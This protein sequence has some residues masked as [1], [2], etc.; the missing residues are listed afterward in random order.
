MSRFIKERYKN[1]KSYAPG[2]QPK[3]SEYVKLNTNE[4]P[5]PPAP[6]VVKALKDVDMERLRL[7]PD[8]TG[9]NLKCKLAKLYDVEPENVFLSNLS[10]IHI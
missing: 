6:S 5:F 7:Y 1:F 10:L 2:E 9:Y 4:S 8:P 3:D